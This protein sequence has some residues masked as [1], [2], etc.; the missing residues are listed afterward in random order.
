MI[1]T[2]LK[3]QN[4]MG[5]INNAAEAKIAPAKS[6]VFFVLLFVKSCLKNI[7]GLDKCGIS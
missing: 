4:G 3:P 5:I 6:R 7:I 2:F 1:R